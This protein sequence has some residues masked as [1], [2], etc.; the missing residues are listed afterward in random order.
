M[1]ASKKVVVLKEL[2]GDFGTEDEQNPKSIMFYP[3][4]QGVADS[5]RSQ[6]FL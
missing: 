6:N 5:S 2:V 4:R 3:S 1:S